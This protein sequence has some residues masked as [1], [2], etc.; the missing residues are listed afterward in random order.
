MVFDVPAS[1]N[2]MS[3][4]FLLPLK[5]PTLTAYVFGEHRGT[6]LSYQG[7]LTMNIG[8]NAPDVITGFIRKK[9]VDAAYRVFAICW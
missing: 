4:N 8:S 1:N 7:I 5:P 9:D 6:D 3:K 2:T